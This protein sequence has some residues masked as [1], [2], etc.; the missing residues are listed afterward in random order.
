MKRIGFITIPK[1][2]GHS[3]RGV[4]FYSQRLLDNLKSRAADHDLEIVENEANCDLVH[5]PFFDLFSRSLPIIKSAK[6][7]VTI[8]DVTPLEFPEHYPTGIK[9][10]FNLQM[11]KLALVGVDMVITDSFASVNS[12]RKYLSVPSNKIR[13]IY[14][15]ADPM[16]KPIKDKSVLAKV[17]KK[18][19]LPDQFILYVGDIGWN[20]N[21][22]ILA[23][24]AE[25]LQTPLVIVGKN[26]AGIEQLDLN[27]PELTH[28][29][30]LSLTNIIRPGF[31][32]DSDLVAMYNLA[33]VYCQPSLAEGFGLPVLEALACNC[34]VVSSNT[35]SLP[36]IGGDAVTYFAPSDLQGLVSA[37]KNPKPGGAAQAA[38]FSWAKVADET[39][40]VYQEI[41]RKQ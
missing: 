14:L 31:V 12:I 5:Y 19:H 22:P 28:L 2:S 26:A 9:G 27:H 32:P 17:K 30:T 36:E 24:A 41:L 8:H 4:G 40:M 29:Q 11:Q 37:L 39:I 7:V 20:K 21:L 38:K 25:Q 15:A 13:L 23:K 33:R 3:V 35:H 18:Y 6:T 10:F 34:P 1:K 16:F